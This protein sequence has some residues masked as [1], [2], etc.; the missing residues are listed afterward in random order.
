[1]GR[2]RLQ[3]IAGDRDGAEAQ[4][5][6]ELFGPRGDRVAAANLAGDDGQLAIRAVG[7]GCDV[8]HDVG[9]GE[10]GERLVRARISA[11]RCGHASR[12]NAT[13][14]PVDGK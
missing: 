5:G 9:A 6:R 7:L 4:K 14:I 10:N 8:A 11:S 13:R 3:S 12:P 1:M 2:V